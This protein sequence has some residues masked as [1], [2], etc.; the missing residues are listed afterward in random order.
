MVN[1]LSLQTDNQS[2]VASQNELSHL[3]VL[4]TKRVTASR[5]ALSQQITTS[6]IR[7]FNSVRL[8]V[9]LLS[10]TAA[11]VLLGAWCPQ[12]SAVGQEKIIEQFGPETAR[13]LMKLGITD[14]FHTPFFLI[15]IFF[16]TLNLIVASFKRVFP[17]LLL[18]K[19]PHNFLQAEEIAKLPQNY[20]FDLPIRASS[21][22][23]RLAL[24]LRRRGFKISVREPFLYAE[25]G[26]ISRLA[27]SITHVGL[28]SL[29]IGVT[30]SSWTGFSGFEPVK[31]GSALSFADSQHSKLWVGRLPDW[32]ARL[33]SSRR[34]D[35]PSGEAKQWYSTLT[36]LDSAKR[37]IKSAEISV[38]NPLSYGGVDIYQSSWG[39]D[40]ILV[41]FNAHER[42][43][44][45]RPMGTRYA[46]FLPLDEAT[47]LIFSVKQQGEPLRLFAKRTEWQAPKLLG[48]ILPGKTVN[49]GSVKLRYIRTVPVSGL[50]YKCDPGLPITFSAFGLIM[51]GVLLSA[52][53]HRFVWAQA[54]DQGQTRTSLYFGGR[55]NKAKI[56][57]ER[58]LRKMIALLQEQCG[59]SVGLSAFGDNDV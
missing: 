31:V 10:L 3:P 21:A 17:K 9:F 18:L 13:T 25:C 5:I 47:V 36:V 42:A 33:D 14:V 58:T 35:Y 4:T 48:Q 52:I 57:F 19:Q 49:L 11:T 41:S 30:I 12:E 22:I 50:Q 37:K 7:F 2:E 1:R 20:C 44:S 39:L 51:L 54:V 26:K 6:I 40:Q 53:P 43:L 8:A 38:N 56:G 45:L 32:S 59:K 24:S 55:S 34:E 23:D 15:L 29:L 16:L 46:A 27:A 28:I